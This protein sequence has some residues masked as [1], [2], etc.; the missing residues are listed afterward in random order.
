MTQ[1]KRTMRFAA[2]AGVAALLL[3]GCSAGSA[4]ETD[5]V[6]SSSDA[7]ADGPR[8]AV[9]YEGGVLIVDGESLE[10]I[11]DLPTE[12][13]VRLNP[14]GDGRHAFVT[15]SEGFQLLDVR[16]PEL[17]DLVVEAAAAGHVVR[18]GGKT[19]LYDDAT[20]DTTI[21]DTDSLADVDG[22]LPEADVVEGVDAHHGVSVVLEDGTFVTTVGDAAG[23]SGIRAVDAGGAE[24][25]AS[26][27]CPGVHGEGTAQGEAVVFGCE[28]GAL[29]FDDGEI[30]KL[31]SPDE[32]GRIG[33]A[34]VSENSPLV[35]MDYKDDPDMEG[36]LLTD[37]ALVDTEAK[38]LEKVAL[39]EGVSYT[40]RG[41]T[42]VE[43][44]DAVLI[45]SDG[46]LHLIDP[47]TGA[48]TASYDAIDAW[49]GP[50]EWQQPHP[51]IAALGNVVYVTDAANS[52]IVTL[53]AAT[54][55]VLASAE[56]PE[57]PNEIAVVG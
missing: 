38:T 55:E 8:V 29:V 45:G 52:T 5:T 54:G 13:F 14:A 35:V 53:D 49:E 19:V 27:E 1:L 4:A 15:T 25:A 18:H 20:S 2:G 50:S 16:E 11:D 33:N 6:P 30:T 24:I 44:G 47:A 42:R 39:P 22:E 9:A 21:F 40:F 41:V 7:P 46:K 10:V 48:I 23:R 17:T 34:Y 28:N 36:Y 56:L 12:D 57:V 31:T 26:A 51:A 37:I 32:Y 43:N 3:A